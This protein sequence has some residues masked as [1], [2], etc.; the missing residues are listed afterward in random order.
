MSYTEKID[1]LDLVITILKEHEKAL[2]AIA[3][4]LEK[5]LDTAQ[6]PDDLDLLRRFYK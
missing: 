1:A 4:R 3:T 6:E 2:D 5:A